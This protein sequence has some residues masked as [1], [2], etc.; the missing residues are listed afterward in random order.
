[1]QVTNPYGDVKH[2]VAGSMAAVMLDVA[3]AQIVTTRVAQKHVMPRK[4]G[5]TMYFRRYH[6]LPAVVAP[7]ADGVNPAATQVSWEDI[8]CVLSEYGA[9]VP[10]TSKTMDMHQDDLFNIES[11]RCGVQIVDT[12]ELVNISVMKGGTSVSYANSVAGRSTVA[13]GPIR[14][15]YRKIERALWDAGAKT[16]TRLIKASP[17]VGTEPVADAFWAMMHT[18]CIADHEHLAGW[19]PVEKYAD[20]DGRVTFERGKLGSIRFLATNNFTPWQSSGATSTTLLAGGSVQSGGASCDV[21]PVI[22]VAEDAF[23]TVPLAGEDRVT[24]KVRLPKPSANDELGRQGSV[25][26]VL[27]H[28]AVILNQ[29]WMERYEC[30]V[31]GNPT[32]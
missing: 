9:W 29:E 13:T 17:R 30:G 26:W 32:W 31:T 18:D 25:G 2:S 23:G 20:S 10:I 6:K 11:E 24:P 5:D 7:L 14:G 28:T 4:S 19:T 15:D 12:V 21:Y 3:T 1:M 27:R 16:M 8:S 22:I